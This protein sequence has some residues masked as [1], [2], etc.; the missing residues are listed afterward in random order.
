MRARKV[1]SLH[2]VWRTGFTKSICCAPN[3]PCSTPVAHCMKCHAA[4]FFCE[5]LDIESDQTH[6]L[7]V[8]ASAAGLAANGAKEMLPAS[9]FPP[10]FMK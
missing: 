4:S 8:G 1:S 10:P 5:K 6:T 3:R 7:G 2:T 9:L